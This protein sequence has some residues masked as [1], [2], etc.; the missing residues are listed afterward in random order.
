[1]SMMFDRCQPD[2]THNQSRSE[3]PSSKYLPVYITWDL[4]FGTFANAK[5]FTPVSLA[6]DLL[7]KTLKKG[8]SRSTNE[9]F[10]ET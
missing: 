5:S 9:I 3:A 10:S 1:M 7:T 6:S 8:R 4:E 2:N